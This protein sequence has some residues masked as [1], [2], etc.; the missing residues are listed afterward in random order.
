MIGSIVLANKY[1]EDEDGR[2][3]DFRDAIHRDY[4]GT[5][6][7]KEV[8][9]DPP[10]RG[11]NGNAFIPL[12]EGAIP[13]RK[14]PY[15]QFGEKEEAMKKIAQDWL[16]KKFIEPPS[17]ENCEWLCQ[18][19]AVAKKSSTFPWRGV[20]DMRGPNSQTQ[21]SNYPLPCIEDILIEQGK[22]HIF[23]V[24]D[25][26]QAF[27]QQPMREDSRPVTCT[28]TPLGIFQWRVNV[29]GLKNASVQFQHMMNDVLES[30][31]HIASCYVDDII[32][33]SRQVE[34]EDLF[35]T[36]DKDLRMVLDLLREST[37]VVDITKC[38][39]F[40]PEVEF[41][42]HILG[43]GKRRPAPGKL[44]AI[45]KWEVPTNISE[46]RSFLGFTNYYAS[47]VEHY[48]DT[49]AILQEKLK[50]PR[51][52]GKKGSK[53]RIAWNERDQ[54]AFDEVK[55]K[56]CSGLELIRVNPD[57]PF[58]LRADASLYAIGATLEQFP[59]ENCLPTREEVIAGKT[60]PV[61]F[62]SR[63][64]TEGQTKWVPRERE[65][66]AI[67]AALEKW[68]NWIGV[69]P[70]LVLTD[71][72]A[73]EWWMKEVI[74][75]P[76]GPL[77]RR[78]RWHLT[79][80]KFDLNIEHVSGKDNFVPDALSRWAYPASKA[81]RDVSKHGSKEDV[82]EV[83]KIK[84]EE[85]REE[86]ELEEI[87]MQNFGRHLKAK[88]LLEDEAK[89]SVNPVSAPA[90]SSARGP[91]KFTF[92]TPRI[93]Q[94]QPRRAEAGPRRKSPPSREVGPREEASEEPFV[95]PQHVEEKDGSSS[96]SVKNETR[97]EEGSQGGEHQDAPL[98]SIYSHRW[99]EWYEECER[100]SQ[101]WEDTISYSDVGAWPEGL[102]VVDGRMFF[103]P[104][105]C[106]PTPLQKEW[107]RKQ[108][109]LLGHP[110]YERLWFLLQKFFEWGKESEANA[111]A[112]RVSQECDT[113]QACVR[114]RNRFGP[115]VSAPIPPALMAN[116]ALDVFQMPRVKVGERS[117][118]CMVVCVDRHSGWLV[119]IPEL[120]QGLTGSKV[121]KAMLKEWYAFGIPTRITSDQ[122]AHFA[123]S[124]W[125]TMCAALGITHIYTQPYHHQANG[126]AERAGQ[127]ILEVLRKF[128][129][130]D[131]LNWVEALPRVLR[132]IHDTPGES[133]LTPYEILFGRER[134]LAHVPYDPPR[135]CEDA[136]EFFEHQD[137]VDQKVANVLNSLHERR[138]NSV[139]A[140]R[141]DSKAL[142]IGTLV[143]YRRPE[144]TGG[145]MDSR[146][147]GPCEVTRREGEHSYEIRTG[148]KTFIKAHRTFLKEYWPDT[149]SEEC[150][151]MYHHKRTVP[152]EKETSTELRVG[153]IL[154]HTV[155]EDGKILFLTQRQGERVDQ[156]EHLPPQDFLSGSAQTLLEYCSEVGLENVL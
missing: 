25:L 31:K 89:R 97:D 47:Y 78:L 7:C 96:G 139:N 126:R 143:W 37:L 142:P 44:L 64:L 46:L 4:D 102:Q 12:K 58:I 19:F 16:D 1:F 122:G 115:I 71:H 14:K 104:K 93:L 52:V 30:V 153:K 76:S 148:Q 57:K 10:V 94:G 111:F 90:E 156:A 39:L 152:L 135:V 86:R 77:G 132:I 73:L 40:V 36:H 66:Y 8:Q 141:K 118:D 70:V 17:G 88:D 27:H 119:V 33:G 106:V 28:Y 60:V 29:M 110:G 113:C 99:G 48:A 116:V 98:G 107:I 87:C 127:Q 147:L 120:Y 22:N 109:S 100:F 123:N 72:K 150:K 69:Q 133:G 140:R 63:K 128:H 131:K 83:E 26:R 151:P 23:S 103:G 42:G 35:V 49:V 84:A 55:R 137:E 85:Q 144:G 24:L 50:V 59:G 62:F 95:T 149:H 32:V 136:Q 34:G 13:Q 125:R 129:T 41:C 145:K 154:G 108:H 65:T 3:T 79:F 51:D 112:K 15:K 5:V 155:D 20:V 68:R 67:V 74:D 61:A 91:L 56:L 9:P 21:K 82:E 114:P 81:W 117:Y 11:L 134:F 138:A 105:L 38:R 18:A 53:V 101:I 130:D 45:E 146:W 6:L 124:W 2:V 54:E 80:S 43:G 121:A 75:P 92:K